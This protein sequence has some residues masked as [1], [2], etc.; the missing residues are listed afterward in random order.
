VYKI[1]IN[2]AVEGFSGIQAMEEERQRKGSV[3]AA[4]FNS[5]SRF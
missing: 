4:Y 3:L 5:D 1:A 2:I